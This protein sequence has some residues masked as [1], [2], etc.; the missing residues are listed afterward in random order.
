MNSSIVTGSGSSADGS[1][2]R[3]FLNFGSTGADKTPIARVDIH[4]PA[5]VAGTINNTPGQ[6][7][8][9]GTNHRITQVTADAT[10]PGDI[11][12]KPE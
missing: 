9:P 12:E 2:R 4:T 5:N 11:G 6:R 10:V 1:G 8:D 3:S 7:I